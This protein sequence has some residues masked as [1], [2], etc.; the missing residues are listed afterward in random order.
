[1]L[2]EVITVLAQNQQI[3]E[4][5]VCDNE[6]V[7]TS[8]SRALE[9]CRQ[10]DVQYL[11]SVTR[12]HMRIAMVNH[13]VDTYNGIEQALAQAKTVLAEKEHELQQA[14]NRFSRA[15]NEGTELDTIANVV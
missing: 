10:H 5:F 7:F 4:V 15:L 12:N 2:Y 1:M 13:A 11:G 8:E 14:C 3:H 9:Y 6:N